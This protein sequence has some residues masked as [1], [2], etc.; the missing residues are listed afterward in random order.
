MALHEA[1][2]MYERC[3]KIQ[4]LNIVGHTRRSLK[5]FWRTTARDQVKGEMKNHSLRVQH[6]GIRFHINTVVWL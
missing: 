3:P 4:T 5:H 6:L 2:L 1:K